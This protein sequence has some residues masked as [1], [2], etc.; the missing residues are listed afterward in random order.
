MNTSGD[1]SACNLCGCMY[2]YAYIFTYGSPLTLSLPGLTRG[3]PAED[4][5]RVQPV[6]RTL[7]SMLPYGVA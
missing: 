4:L 5:T 3:E 1:R 6:A 7:P 2:V